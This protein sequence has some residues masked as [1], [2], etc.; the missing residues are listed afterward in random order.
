MREQG[1]P[2]QADAVQ[3]FVQEWR[4]TLVRKLNY[5]VSSRGMSWRQTVK[6]LLNTKSGS[7]KEQIYIRKLCEI[8][9]VAQ[10][11]GQFGRNFQQIVREKRADL[12]DH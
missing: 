3:R 10:T 6:L 8:N 11:L 2:G 7:W 9:S 5:S 4:K 1:F 12:F